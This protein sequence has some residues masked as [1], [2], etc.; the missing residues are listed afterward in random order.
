[1]IYD[2]ITNFVCI[3][4]VYSY[5]KRIKNEEKYNYFINKKY[6]ICVDHNNVKDFLSIKDNVIETYNSEYGKY[7]KDIWSYS[8]LLYLLDNIELCETK[9]FM[10]STNGH[11]YKLKNEIIND[12]CISDGGENINRYYYFDYLKKYVDYKNIDKLKSF[13][14]KEHHLRNAFIINKKLAH[15]ILEYVLN[16][17]ILDDLKKYHLFFRHYLFHY[18]FF[19][20]LD[21]YNPDCKTLRFIKR[22]PDPKLHIIE[23]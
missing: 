8:G 7:N 14:E 9:Y 4:D 17:G 6:F 2:N 20:I 21:T 1:M 22:I 3:H 23:K 19:Y 11:F 15:E 18:V 13:F 10:Y 16:F 5:Q 12:V